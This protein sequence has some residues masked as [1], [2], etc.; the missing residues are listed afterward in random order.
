MHGSYYKYILLEISSNEV[1][2]F[3]N[4]RVRPVP[5]DILKNEH[6]RTRTHPHTRKLAN[7]QDDKG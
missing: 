1:S 2:L 7:S 3:A 5:M 4:C 6:K